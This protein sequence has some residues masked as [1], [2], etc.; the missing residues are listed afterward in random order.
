MTGSW[1]AIV[2]PQAGGGRAGRAAHALVE[3]LHQHGIRCI[4]K[5]TRS[6]GHAEELARTA[7]ANVAGIVAVGGDGTVHEVVNGL[8]LAAPP[9]LAVLPCG[10]GNDWAKGLGLPTIPTA[11]AALIAQGGTRAVPVGRVCFQDGP[12]RVAKRFVNGA[13]IG[14]DAAVLGA[15]PRHGPR[16]LA[17]LSGTLRALGQFEPADVT[18]QA[19][20]S[21]PRRMRVCLV[22]A[23]LGPIAGGGMV[24][25]PHARQRDGYLYRMDV[26]DLPVW[27]LLRLLPALYR[28]TLDRSPRVATGRAQTLRWDTHA[29]WRLEADG[30]LLGTG[31][32]E[33]DVLTERL[34]VISAAPINGG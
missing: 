15:L 23:A 1:L 7:G 19:D 22:Y 12:N 20:L 9:R 34:Q 17:Y 14:L 8:D 26:P 33:L 18:I 10:T 30:Q 3:S 27:Q 4:I 16:R 2:N 11:L 29:P 5:E 24:L 31:P 13:G 25:A 6:A 21:E 32:I 28:G